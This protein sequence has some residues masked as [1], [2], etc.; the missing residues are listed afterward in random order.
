MGLMR[1][2][3]TNSENQSGSNSTVEWP[4]AAE[5][6]L[7]FLLF[8]LYA[9]CP[10]PNVNEAH[11]LAKAK[12]YWDPA[13]CGGD[14]FLESA[15][16]HLVFYW[17]AGWLTRL[18]PLAGVAWVGR[19]TVW[20]LLALAWQR[21]AGALVPK[22]GYAL[23]AAGMVVCLWDRFHMAGEWVVGGF[24]AKGFAYA[25]LFLA[26]EK[27]VRGRWAAACWA[28]GAATAFHVLV[29]GWGMLALLFVMLISPN[30][31]RPQR[32]EMIFGLVG[33]AV[34]SLPGLWPALRLTAGTNVEIAQTAAEIYV[35]RLS[36]H[37][38]IYKFA[39]RR[40]ACFVAMLFTW[41]VLSITLRRGLSDGM[42]R[43]QWFVA[44]SLLFALLGA[45]L[46]YFSIVLPFVMRLLRFYWFRLADVMVPS[47]VALL[48]VSSLA[49]RP[50]RWAGLDTGWVFAAILIVTAG[51]SLEHFLRARANL[52]ARV[53]PRLGW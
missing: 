3:P 31:Q 22:W 21:L 34:L 52:P 32:R 46:D 49:A 7:I 40:I 39:P 28:L 27:L 18:M 38:E 9:G 51:C 36:H 11:Y 50:K 25:L 43:L 33:A 41:I 44:A 10:P 35:S 1:K 5:V 37:M 26:L 53:R 29:G 12:H 48:A 8:F 17:T 2:Q 13:W 47:G 16:A 24:E 42:R 19:L 23:F 6:L 20:L 4:V 15:D 30:G 14:A 45:G